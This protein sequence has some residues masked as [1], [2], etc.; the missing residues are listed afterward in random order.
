MTALGGAVLQ[1]LTAAD[2]QNAVSH[3]ECLDPCQQCV[4]SPQINSLSHALQSQQQPSQRET[5]TSATYCCHGNQL[6]L[7]V[8][9]AIRFLVHCV[10]TLENK[11]PAIHNYLL[12][13]YAQEKDDSQLLKFLSVT[14]IYTC[15]SHHCFADTRL[16]SNQ[17]L[18]LT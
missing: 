10:R 13:L 12:S 1:V 9:Q 11:D 17:R 6:I 3:S 5:C 7:Q 8:N 18:I 16:H 4:R 15:H 14:F 2:E